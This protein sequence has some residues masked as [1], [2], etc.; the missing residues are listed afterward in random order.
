[1]EGSNVSGISAALQPRRY[2]KCGGSLKSASTAY[3]C[4][5][6]TPIRPLCVGYRCVCGEKVSIAR[7]FPGENHTNAY[8]ATITVSCSQGHAATVTADQ[9]A[10]LDH[11]EEYDE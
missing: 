2:V 6:S 8:P 7:F 5:V 4:R 11:W 9:F 10:V 3:N 1:M